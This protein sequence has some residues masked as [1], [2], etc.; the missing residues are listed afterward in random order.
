MACTPAASELIFL[1]QTSNHSL[2][3]AHFIDRNVSVVQ[4]IET[5]SI[6][7]IVRFNNKNKGSRKNLIV[8]KPD[9]CKIT[10]QKQSLKLGLLNIRSL[11]PKAVII[12]EII[13]DNS[14]DVI[15][16]TETWLKAN[17]YFGLNE[18]CPPGY[19][20]KN[21]CRLIGCGG[22]VATIYREILNVTQR[23]NYRFNSFEILMLNVTLS[24]ISKKSLL[25]LALATIYRPPGPYADFLKEFAD[26]LSDLL[27]N[28]DKALI[29][30][31]FNIHVDNINDTL[32]AAFTDL[33]NSFGVEQNVTGPTHRL[34]HTLDLIISHGI[35]PTDIEI[36]PQSDDVSDHYLVTCV[37]HTDDI[38]QIAP[39]YR[40]GR[41]ILPTTI[42]KFTNNLPDLSQLLIVPEHANDLEEMTSSML[43]AQN[44][45]VSVAA[46]QAVDSDDGIFFCLRTANVSVSVSLDEPETQNG[47]VSVSVSP[48]T[49][50]IKSSFLPGLST[51][52]LLPAL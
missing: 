37:L 9:F 3:S 29:V 28:V 52:G 8:I 40:L 19:R 48:I 5:V 43:E 1:S 20:Y 46:S 16:L 51:G 22:G 49:G 25:S 7:R 36:L 47:I 30:G 44:V 35:N 39:R 34:N 4:S 12:K 33:L 31:D 23:T 10:E 50:P 27:V 26:F 13:T 24:D 17:H 18:S 21:K 11:T 41:T 2:C 14:L 32:G 45:V 38:C 6:P 42:D 15:C